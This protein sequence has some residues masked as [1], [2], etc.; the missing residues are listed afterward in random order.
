MDTGN[1]QGIFA[2]ECPVL[3]TYTMTA[4]KD[5]KLIRTECYAQRNRVGD[6]KMIKIGVI[7]KKKMEKRDATVNGW[8]VEAFLDEEEEL[9]LKQKHYVMF[10]ISREMV[11]ELKKS[12][13]YM[14][15][16]LKNP[17]EQRIVIASNLLI[18]TK[19]GSTIKIKVVSDEWRNT[20]G[21]EKHLF[22]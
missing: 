19:R 10:N 13:F 4:R 6:I 9:Q 14:I 15:S 22:D 17:F 1:F 16:G 18:T 8:Q 11:K 12:P 3:V 21:I 7:F 2:R 5:K 20:E